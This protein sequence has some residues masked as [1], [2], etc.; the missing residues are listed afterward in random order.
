ME[1]KIH[2]ES[3]LEALST[4]HKTRIVNDD[5]AKFLLLNEINYLNKTTDIEPDKFKRMRS[6]NSPATSEN[7]YATLIN[8]ID[9]G[10]RTFRIDRDLCYLLYFTDLKRV[11]AKNLRLPFEC[12]YL[13][14]FEHLNFKTEDK[15]YTIDSVYVK[16]GVVANEKEFQ[17]YLFKKHSVCLPEACKG[18]ED[19]IFSLNLLF[20]AEKF[21][22]SGGE[23]YFTVTFPLIE[24]DVL[25]QVKHFFNSY[26][27]LFFS[28]YTINLLSDMVKF[29][30][31]CVL[32]INSE[33]AIIKN[34]TTYKKQSIKTRRR[35]QRNYATKKPIINRYSLN[36]KIKITTKDRDTYNK[37]CMGSKARHTSTWIVRGHWHGYWKNTENVSDDDRL[38]V[39]DDDKQKVL[40][41]KF[42]QPY[43]KGNRDEYPI[44]KKYA[45]K[46]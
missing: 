29:I 12:F 4:V 28:E 37:I 39:I 8:F 9:N 19:I 2:F 40:I 1:Q 22:Y 5:T 3:V 46:L 15:A 13:N 26:G 32:F 27:P 16:G 36:T 23:D 20:T 24:G 25:Y 35:K 30:L 11:D 43:V 21:D 17:D 38:E 10:K 14:G 33:E 6:L 42:I 7:F 18:P 34:I 45:V 44:T 41:K 31:N